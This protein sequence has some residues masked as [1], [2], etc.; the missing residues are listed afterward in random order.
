MESFKTKSRLITIAS[1]II[2]ILGF[3]TQNM[4]ITIL[5]TKYAYLA[6]MIIAAITFFANQLS[7][8]KRVTVAEDLIA[9]KVETHFA[10]VVGTEGVTETEEVEEVITEEEGEGC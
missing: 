1:L 4:W 3:I 8:E 5:G 7:E 10:G 2:T 6:P 9:N